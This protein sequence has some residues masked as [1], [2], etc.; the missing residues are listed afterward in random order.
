MIMQ[1]SKHCSKL[2][3]LGKITTTPLPPKKQENSAI[4]DDFLGTVELNS[5][6]QLSVKHFKVADFSQQIK[7]WG[8][9]WPQPPIKEHWCFGAEQI[10]GA[11]LLVAHQQRIDFA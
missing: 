6:H 9:V 8:D 7:N 10:K 11:S 5:P 3:L 4:G 1:L 2:C